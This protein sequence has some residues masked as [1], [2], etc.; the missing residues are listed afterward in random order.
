ME[1]RPRM[2]RSQ[3]RAV[4]PSIKLIAC[5]SSGPFMPT[6]IE[7]DRTVLEECYDEVDGISLH[8]YFGNAEETKGGSSIYLAMNL[9]MDRQIEEIIAVCDRCRPAS[10]QARSCS[11]PST[12]GT[13]GIAPAA[14][15]P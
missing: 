9:A 5:G 4:D 11:S 12:N 13:Y 1:A 8:R 14:A 6:Y 3:M 2:P 15:T 7:W 10:V